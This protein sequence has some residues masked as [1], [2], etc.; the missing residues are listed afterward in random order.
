ML[1]DNTLIGHIYLFLSHLNATY[2]KLSSKRKT[3]KSSPEIIQ[4]EEIHSTSSYL[5]E[6]LKQRDLP[7]CSVVIT[8]RQTAGRGQPGNKWESSP[9]KNITFS[10]VFYPEMI[11]ANQQFIISRTVAVAIVTAIEKITGPVKIK[12]PN[13]IY[14]NDRKLGGILIENSLQGSII[15]QCIAGIGI[16]VNQEKFSKEIPNPVSIKNI[17][18]KTHELTTLF[19][20]VYQS[21]AD[22]YKLLL[23]DNSKIIEEIYLNHLY[24]KTG[25][26]KYRDAKG[27]FRA[28][29]SKIDPAG[30]LYLAREDGKIS[31]YAFKE[32][33]FIH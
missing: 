33:E 13:D 11:P 19:Q 12:W 4:P 10:I 6:L 2:D 27:T 9:G 23:E 8:T 3:M 29:F 17:T 31:R 20:S 5:K 14:W 21:L 22:H 16:N 25:W 7:E 26:H 15:N 18:G 32:V 28:E 24:R 30:Y 1:K